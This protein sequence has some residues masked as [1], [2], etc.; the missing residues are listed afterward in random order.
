MLKIKKQL[1]RMVK[2]LLYPI[3]VKPIK[4]IAII[5]KAINPNQNKKSLSKYRGEE[6]ATQIQ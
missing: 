3:I 6:I 4:I 1:L 2:I 5:V